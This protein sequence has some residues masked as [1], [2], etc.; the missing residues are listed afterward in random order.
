MSW[1]TVGS[2][3]SLEV[4]AMTG[5]VTISEDASNVVN[6]AS[7]KGCMAAPCSS[8]R[9]VADRDRSAHP[10]RDAAWG[11][12]RGSPHTRADDST[13]GSARKQQMTRHLLPC[14]LCLVLNPLNH[15]L[16]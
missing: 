8:A 7:L 1:S 2:K 13:G 11:G 14:T 3:R 6:E 5:A 10:A 12:Y 9:L 15:P 16:F 4:C